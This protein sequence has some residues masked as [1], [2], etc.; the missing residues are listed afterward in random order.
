[1]HLSSGDS[2]RL[3]VQSEVSA[4]HIIIHRSDMSARSNS[5]SETR[6]IVY[7]VVFFLLYIVFLTITVHG[8]SPDFSI[9]CQR[10]LNEK[11]PTGIA[12]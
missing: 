11:L 5:Y 7:T 10:I 2:S 6:S 8:Y 1:M 4:M 3:C 9:G 12:Q